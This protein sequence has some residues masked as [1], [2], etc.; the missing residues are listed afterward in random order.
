MSKTLAEIKNVLGILKGHF[1]V[2]EF[3]IIF[4]ADDKLLWGTVAEY[5][6]DGILLKQP[7]R[8]VFVDYDY[9]ILIAHDGF[10][11]REEGGVYHA[12]NMDT[13]R[14][15]DNLRKEITL[16]KEDEKEPRRIRTGWGDP[17]ILDEPVE[18]DLINP[19]ITEE[20]GWYIEALS[21]I[22]VGGARAMAFSLS[23][24]LFDFEVSR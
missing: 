6:E 13:K 20:R 19:G 21:M 22:H 24:S 1:K 15:S 23:E 8:S 7:T 16:S 12:A 10:P 9:I 18:F 5:Q 2:G 14:I 4:D 17:L 3:V 11:M